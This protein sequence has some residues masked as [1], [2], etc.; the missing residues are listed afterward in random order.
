M[1]LLLD[2]LLSE[3]PRYGV[4]PGSSL[5]LQ[6]TSTINGLSTSSSGTVTMSF[7]PPIGAADAPIVDLAPILD[8]T[9]AY[10]SDQLLPLG[11]TPGY[12][13]ERWTSTGSLVSQNALKEQLW[14]VVG[15]DF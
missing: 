3:P 14:L 10:H 9:A 2:L 15:K 11:A 5:H 4:K 6:M 13:V 1:S 8:S 12:W 7:N